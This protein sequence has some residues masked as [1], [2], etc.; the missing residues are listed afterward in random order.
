MSLAG[1]LPI[2]VQEH[3]DEELRSEKEE[4]ARVLYV[5]A[6]RARDLL[7]LCA[8]G[9]QAH[10]GW[11]ATFNPVLYP[12]ELNSF[13]P[14]T[15]HPP[16][17][18]QFGNDNIVARP[19]KAMRTQ[20]SV[21][22]GLHNSG[23][24]GH[25]VVWWDPSVLPPSN[26]VR[27]ASSLT[28]FLTEDVGK[29]RSEEGIRAHEEWQRQRE[30]VRQLAGKPQWTVVTATAHARILTENSE[31]LVETLAIDFSR[32]HGK[33]F[34]TL[35]HAVLSTVELNAN[36]EGIRAVARLQGRVLG[37]SEEEVA[38]AVETVSRALAH[39]VR[40]RQPIASGEQA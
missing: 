34:G 27:S 7:V 20:G 18:P 2:E 3:A 33:R 1:C 21:S 24:G 38:G 37:A 26:D 10:D 31:V 40:L 32:P 6:T 39:P 4:A 16:G 36:V 13:N 28:P 14:K 15:R 29:V 8:V 22:P 23:V 17:C 30:S 25:E 9:D 11:L 35:V 5:A 12:S 19:R